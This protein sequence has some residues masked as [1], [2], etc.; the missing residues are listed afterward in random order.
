MEIL[1]LNCSFFYGVTQLFDIDL[2]RKGWKKLTKEERTLINPNAQH[3][4]SARGLA[5]TWKC[6]LL[7]YWVEMMYSVIFTKTC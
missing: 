4:E 2:V 6:I 5:Q 3:S 1:V 7:E